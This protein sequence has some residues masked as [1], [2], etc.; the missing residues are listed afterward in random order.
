MIT[1]VLANAILEKPVDGN[2]TLIMDESKQSM[3]ESK[4]SITY[5]SLNLLEELLKEAYCPDKL[6]VNTYIDIPDLLAHI[7]SHLLLLIPLMLF[8][9]DI[10]GAEG[11]GFC[12]LITYR[13]S[14]FLSFQM[15]WQEKDSFNSDKID[16]DLIKVEYDKSKEVAKMIDLDDN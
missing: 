16:D 6:D 2:Q 13:K 14:M 15:K 1:P 3:D 12:F 5:K 7:D 11:N 9:Y 4:P 8:N 10:L